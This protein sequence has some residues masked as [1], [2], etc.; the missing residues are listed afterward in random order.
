MKNFKQVAI[1]AARLTGA[2]LMKNYKKLQSKDIKKK[3]KHD[4]VTKAD[5]E[6]NK[7]IIKTIKKD[8]PDHDFLSEETGFED[9]PDIYK[10]VIDPLDGTVNYNMEN[11]LFCTALS[12]VYKRNILFSII[13]APYLK[14]FFYAEKG[15]GA[16]LNGKQIRVSKQ[17]D[18]NEALILIGRSHHRLSHLRFAR[19]QL[20]LKENVMNIRRLGSGSLDLAYTAVGRVE[21]CLLVPPDISLWDSLAGV[22]LVRE[23]GGKVTNFNGQDWNFKR[24][25]VI[26][27]NG[28]VHN[29]LLKVAKKWKL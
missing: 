24:R 6:A 10:W 20:K 14:E 23:A 28:L 2:S 8:F 13:Y 7:I 19:V 22:L 11:P 12:L 4:I 25:G 27:S 29:Q 3:G 18:L 9:N 1:K 5:F 21:A 26:A 15:K 17:K 16:F